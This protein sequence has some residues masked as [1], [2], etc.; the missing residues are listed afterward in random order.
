MSSVHFSLCSTAGLRATTDTPDRAVS[1]LARHL[2]DVSDESCVEWQITAPDGAVRSGR[3]QF[4]AGGDPWQSRS[5]AISDH[6][7]Q[8]HGVLLRDAARL[9]TVGGIAR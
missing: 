4:P 3:F 7:D 8:V 1:L 5:A 2:C 9:M 6:V